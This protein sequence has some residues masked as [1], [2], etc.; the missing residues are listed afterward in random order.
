MG[1]SRDSRRPPSR[2][3]PRSGGRPAGPRLMAERPGVSPFVLPVLPET[4]SFR[5]M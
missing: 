5:T 3:V 4:A 2:V 1:A